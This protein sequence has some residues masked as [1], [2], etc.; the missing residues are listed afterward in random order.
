M[1]AGSAAGAEPI[2]KSRGDGGPQP[3]TLDRADGQGAAA[4]ARRLFLMVRSWLTECDERYT[5][6]VTSTNDNAGAGTYRPRRQ[7]GP[8]H[9][10][11]RTVRGGRILVCAAARGESRPTRGGLSH[12][13]FWQQN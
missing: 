13:S 9:V 6:R 10:R 11:L 5:Q 3:I 7:F 8:R 12:F 4:F 1:R 2:S